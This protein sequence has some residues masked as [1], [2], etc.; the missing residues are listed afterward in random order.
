MPALHRHY[1]RL[2]NQR[3]R[4]A[5]LALFFATVM[6]SQPG[7]TTIVSSATSGM[8]KNLS[9]AILNSDDPQTVADGAPAYLLLLDSFLGDKPDN[10]KLLLSAA[11]LYGAYVGVFVKD[12][13][14]AKNMSQHAF[15]YSQQ[16]ICIDYE[17]Y[18]DA[19]RLDFN[20]FNEQ[21]RKLEKDD[22]P[23][24]YTFATTWAGR[25]Q[26][27]KSDWNVIAELPRVKAIMQRITELNPKYMDGNVY[28]YLGVLNTLLPAAFGGKPEL[29]KL[30]FEK[31]IIMSDGKNLMAKVL[32][33][34]KYAR[35]VFN[36]EL[37]DSLLKEVL[38]AE[39]KVPDLTLTNTLAQQ[40][41]KELLSTSKDYF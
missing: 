37:H 18:C 26:A 7:C 40:K 17:N 41:A 6:L 33:A 34:E 1:I 12:P 32:F 30:Q 15:A 3:L 28:L 35:L 2:T 5:V 21:L 24:W 11:T 13:D 25:I 23:A 31:A 9:K 29:G 19:T 39:A 16:A 27:N 10:P 14:R 22:V 8:A 20:T 36:Q 4:L 38:S